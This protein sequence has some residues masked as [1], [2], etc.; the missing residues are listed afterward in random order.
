MVCDETGA[1]TARNRHAT[2]LFPGLRVG[3]PLTE[4]SAGP[5]GRAAAH[6]EPEF[7]A[8]HRG[9]R[10]RGRVERGGGRA[11]WLVSD[12]AAGRE[13]GPAPVHQD[14]SGAL[15]RAT[16]RLGVSLHHG[17]TA[18]D[19][20][21]AA[22]PVL[23]DTAVLVLPVHGRRTAWYRAGPEGDQATGQTSARRIEDLPPLA[24]TL[25]GLLPRPA[26]FAG[27]ELV[28]LALGTP[29]DSAGQALVLELPGGGVP[30]GALILVRDPP[31]PP[32]DAPDTELA[33]RFADR[34][35]PA[36]AT[37]DM[38]SRQADTTAAVR[39]ELAPEPLPEVAGVGLGAAYRP[40]YEG[41]DISGDFYH[42]AP[43]PG[44]GVAFC[45]GDVCGKGTEAAVLAGLV[46][47]S[48][49]VLALA[50]PEP[51]RQLRL[52]N[53]ALLGADN[54]YTTLVTG[55]AAPAPG[56]GLAVTVAGGGH[57][58]PLVLRADGRVEPVRI[59]GTLV[60]VLPDAVFDRSAFLLRPGEL[61]LLHS[62]GVS[63]AR[64]GPAGHE[65][66]GDERLARAL[67]GCAGMPAGAVAERVE[68]L[69]TQWLAGRPHDDIAVLAVQAPPRRA[70]DAAGP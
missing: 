12:L 48:L 37:A 67:A 20:V 64:G 60:G 54:R 14:G 34:A 36:L 6:G 59:D 62:D 8:A 4:A 70:R 38:Y 11:V 63:E 41:L 15:D 26:V 18:R 13:G 32:W 56:G 51:I 35:G 5:L 61:M 57:L 43:R 19:I 52:L 7:D 10:L 69:T 21:R 40:A 65:L 27:R 31:R 3:D 23:A 30:A 58:P 22:V 50:E 66:Y 2:R 25:S 47:Q 33:R 39:A 28:A 17:R 53:R 68:I 45:F 55:H 44:G 49:R 1:V 24:D 16:R 29:P 9:R 46:K 42:V